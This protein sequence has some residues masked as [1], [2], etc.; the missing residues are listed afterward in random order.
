[1]N[2]KRDVSRL[3]TS[4]FLRLRFL[5]VCGIL[6]SC[7]KDGAS[8]ERGDAHERIGSH[9]ATYA[10]DCGCFSGLPDKEITAPQS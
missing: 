10:R 7:K 2:E 1:M 6:V 5:S 9:R 4:L 8:S 3:D